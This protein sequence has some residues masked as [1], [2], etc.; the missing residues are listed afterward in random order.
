MARRGGTLARE[1]PVFG[2]R[3]EAV[4]EPGKGVFPIGWS[5]YCVYSYARPCAHCWE[6]EATRAPGCMHLQKS[7]RPE[8]KRTPAP[9]AQG[10]RAATGRTCC[11]GSGE[12]PTMCAGPEDKGLAS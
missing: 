8:D 9:T 7:G 6:T 11:M 1:H 3:C 2:V 4:T 12:H 10:S 5:I